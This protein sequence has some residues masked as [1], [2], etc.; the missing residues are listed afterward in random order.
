M[1]PNRRT[2]TTVAGS[3]LSRTIS[4]RRERERGP[5]PEEKVSVG[6]I[7]IIVM[8]KLSF[9][10]TTAASL[11]IEVHLPASTGGGEEDERGAGLRAGCLRPAFCC[12]GSRVAFG[13]C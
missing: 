6:M 2:W 1:R 8:C 3:T 12:F 5:K 7:I 9:Q 4:R 10:V 11:L 13:F